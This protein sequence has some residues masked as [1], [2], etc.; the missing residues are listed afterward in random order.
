MEQMK[1]EEKEQ[2]REKKPSREIDVVELFKKVI[3][4]KK[5]L[6]IYIIVSAIIG[7]IIALAIPKTYTAS[8]VLAPES[9]DGGLSEGLG[10]IASSFGINLGNMGSEDAIYPDVYPEIF[11][12]TDFILEL[13]D[14][15]VR[16]KE[17]DRLRTYEEHLKEDVRAPF[18][19]YPRMWIGR[20]F[21]KKD[22]IAS[23]DGSYDKM[24][25][26]RKDEKLCDQ[27]RSSISCSIS[28][29]TGIIYIAVDDQDPLVA[30][31]L[32]DTLQSRLQTYIIT[33][34]TQKAQN[35]YAYYTAMCEDAEEQYIA[36][37]QTYSSYADSHFDVLLQAYQQEMDALENDMQ[38]KYNIYNQMMLQK[39]S[40]EAKIQERTPSFTI[41]E[42]SYM[43]YEASSIPRTLIVIIFIFLGCC[44][45]ALWVLWGR[46]IFKK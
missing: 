7:V 26:S 32:A 22:S 35:D 20:L 6:G 43:P 8:V 25:I 11:S 36:A 29:K 33:Y 34:R 19:K 38:L 31:I 16:L 37:R 15:P 30:T 41:V 12:S 1:T 13:F 10:G 46:Q 23:S 24:I 14:V 18:W 28:K 45:D 21:Q 5:L 2:A 27:I 44:A 17:D 3:K 42:S 9:S 4:E 40:A 39:Q